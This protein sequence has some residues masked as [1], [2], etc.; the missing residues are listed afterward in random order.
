MR[1]HRSCSRPLRWQIG[2]GSSLMPTTL[3]SS[4]APVAHTAAPAVPLTRMQERRSRPPARQ[5]AAACANA[6]G[7]AARPRCTNPGSTCEHPRGRAT[8]SK[9]RRAARTDGSSPARPPPALRAASRGLR[10]CSPCPTRRPTDAESPARVSRPPRRSSSR[11]P[12]AC[13]VTDSRSRTK[14]RGC[15][16]RE[17]AY[18]RGRIDPNPVR[19]ARLVSPLSRRGVTLPTAPAARSS[20]R[21]SP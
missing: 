21:A 7:R 16:A 3:A 15:C 5:S 2:V 12:A 9:R 13:C 11:S 17:R 20:R 8:W 10:H 4:T 19:P 1:D 14:G 6:R 18:H